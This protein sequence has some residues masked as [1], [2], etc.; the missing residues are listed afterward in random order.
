MST[1]LQDLRVALRQL[2][3]H[4]G[5][6]LVVVVTLALGIGATTT[7]FAVLN[8]VAFKPLPFADPDRLVALA[9]VDRQTG[10]WSPPSFDT[11]NA[12]QQIS[13]VWSASAAY[14]SAPVSVAG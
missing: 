10:R 5:F 1:V 14:N 3:A 8:G 7:C 6:V 13:G 2:S 12:L 11:F 4:P 9:I